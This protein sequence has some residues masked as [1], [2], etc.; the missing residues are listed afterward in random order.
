MFFELSPYFYGTSIVLQAICV[1]HCIRRNNQNKWIWIIVFLPFIGSLVYIFTEIINKRDIQTVGAGV[2]YIFNP[3]G[4]VRR[5]EQELH[6]ADTFQNRIAL[7][8]AYLAT[9]QVQ[10]AVAL[11]EKSL[12]GNFVDNEHVLKQL[13]L[14]Y[15]DEQQ[16]QKVVDAAQK[17][18]TRPQ[19]NRSRA[20]IYYVIALEKTG[21]PLK[22][23]EEFAKLGGRFSQYEARFQYGKFLQRQ[24]RTEEATALFNEIIKEETHLGPIERRENKYWIQMAKQELKPTR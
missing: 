7:A 2:S 9:G 15:Y 24:Q 11:Y 1:I 17:I 19:F 12:T 14:A 4:T 6:F 20:H 5:L 8:D 13:M 23:E 22:A 10:K 18:Y 16:F 21:N 3:G